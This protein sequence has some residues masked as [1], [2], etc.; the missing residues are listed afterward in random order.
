MARSAYLNSLMP[1]STPD[2][3]PVRLTGSEWRRILR[4]LTPSWGSALAILF[5]LSAAAALGV[6]PGLL[7][8]Q[9]ID[10]AI[11]HK[12][13]QTLALLVA[14]MILA[15]LAAN[16]LGVWQSY[17]VTRLG[18]DVIYG[19]RMEMHARLLAQSLQFY[20][21][22]RSGEI[23]SRLQSDVASIRNVVS[24]TMV[25]LIS[26]TLT[27]VVTALVILHL[28]WRLALIALGILPVFILPT[29]KVGRARGD[30]AKETQQKVAEFTAYMQERLSVGG[31]LLMRLFGAQAAERADFSERAAQ[32]RQLVIKQSTL[33][34]W[35]LLFIMSFASVGPALIYL[36]GGWEAIDGRITTGTIV[37]FVGF[38][39]RLYAPATSL[40]NAQVDLISA[41]SLFQRIFAWLDL[42]VDMTEPTNPV[43]IAE[44]K[45]GLRFDGVSLRYGAERKVLDGI[46]FDL[47]PGR[48]LAL[49]G[50]SG[51]GKTSLSYL[52]TR[53]YD[54]TEGRVLLDGVDLRDLDFA[55][56]TRLIAV[57]T[58][59][60]IFFNASVRDSLL[61]AKPD[62]DEAELWRALDI[63]HVRDVVEA[64]PDR[65][66]TVIG[67]RGYKLSGGEKQRLAIARV[68]LRDPRLIILDE[69]TSSLDSRSEARISEAMKTLLAGR[70]S[71]VIAHRLR[72]VLSADDI[73][74]MDH[75]RIVERGTHAAL[76]AQGG[77]YQKLYDEQFK[78]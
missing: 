48:M 61:Y 39:G 12:D 47:A 19:I 41:A 35:F 27:V 64:L 4:Y 54:P 1:S 13:F 31:F 3:P 40:V 28:D 24:N 30:V 10:Q 68:A 6:V 52:A 5:C 23:Q 42:P 16:L 70:S 20:T 26:N 58:Q 36:V 56:L 69:A 29:R 22:T 51:A 44:P 17:V 8:R 45:G 25:N 11:P 7:I 46:D 38:L 34:R 15:P 75:G 32:L 14:G 67:E 21:H 37:A 76:L 9:V 65:L 33:G 62:A 49:V 74:V 50:P 59:E 53:L 77:L 55:Q 2:G 66:D 63:A 60:A 71:L 43:R 72:T 57:V 73:L 18:E 78:T